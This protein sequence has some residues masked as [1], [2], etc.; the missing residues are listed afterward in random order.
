[1]SK[2]N[3]T[4]KAYKEV[5]ENTRESMIV[6]YLPLVKRIVDKMSVY[7]P[8][9][10]DKDDLIEAGIVGLIDAVDKYDPGKNCKFSTY[11]RFRIKG[12][13]MDELRSLDIMPKSMRQKSKQ[14]EETYSRLENMLGRAPT[15]KEMADELGITEERYNK[16]IYELRSA[17]IINFD[18]FKSL[19]IDDDDNDGF[20]ALLK[21]D[22]P[23][24]DQ[25]VFFKELCD[26]LAE[27]IENLPERA[28]LVITLYYYEDMTLTEIAKILGLAKSTV[29]ETHAK[30]LL[31]LRSRLKKRLGKE[32]VSNG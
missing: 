7:L 27:E 11:A 20:E 10:V 22:E 14:I 26:I 28:K 31:M 6:E 25:N 12:A 13:I 19:K 4:A 16:L 2:L 5:Q 8:P 18:D 32:E 30:A 15:E 3:Q 23:A 24:P 17:F 9:S 21:S 29:S 1:M